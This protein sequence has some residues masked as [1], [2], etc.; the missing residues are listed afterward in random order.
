MK[1]ATGILT[2]DWNR[3]IEEL[4]NDGWKVISKY[5]GFDAGIDF[6]FLILKF[7]KKKIMLAWDNW[8][9]GKIKCNDDIM[10]E[11]SIKFGITFT[12]GK[13]ENLTPFIIALTRLQNYFF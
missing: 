12:Y 8:T 7:K 5:E 11:L 6:D 1:I 10:D 2:E 3:I 13:P 9:E 4:M